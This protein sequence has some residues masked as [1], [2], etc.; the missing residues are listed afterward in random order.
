M[1]NLHYNDELEELKERARRENE[2]KK[3]WR[4]TRQKG[5]ANL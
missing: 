4:A 1:Q 2:Q 3:V 5:E